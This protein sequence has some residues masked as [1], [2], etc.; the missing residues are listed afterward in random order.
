[1]VSIT[2]DEAVWAG[3]EVELV[4]MVLVAGV[5]VFAGFVAFV[6]DTVVVVGAGVTV[7]AG[8]VVIFL[9]YFKNNDYNNYLTLLY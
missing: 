1:M 3:V 7:V 4:G 8:F 6:V 5:V 2:V 9:F